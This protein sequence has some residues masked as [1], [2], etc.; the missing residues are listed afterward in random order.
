MNKVKKS[1]TYGFVYVLVGNR[2]C[3][4]L[5]S[6]IKSVRLFDPDAPIRV[7][8][9]KAE[10]AWV[11][12]IGGECGV[13]TIVFERD[14]HDTREENRNSSYM[15]LLACKESPW[16]ITCYLDNDIYVVH[17]SFWG[18][19][20][21]AEK[22]GMCMVENPRLFIKDAIMGKGDLDIGADVN[23]YDKKFLEDMPYN[24]TALN[25]GIMFFSKT[26]R[27]KKFLNALIEEQKTNPS[28]GQAGLY[29]TIW[30]TG[31]S[32]YA[33]TRNWLVCKSDAGKIA[34]ITLH[35][36]HPEVIAWW[37]AFMTA[38]GLELKA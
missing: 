14:K 37:N 20:K 35:A 24:M 13:E 27:D 9:E 28:R 5:E 31:I 29:R 36:G 4:H 30:K 25:M 34:P 38:E 6:S 15:R 18:G 7:Y 21:I 23:D 17:D 32:P 16:D 1:K 22:F 3:N 2:D 33:L 11:N 8:C 19:F 10:E 12:S 26:A